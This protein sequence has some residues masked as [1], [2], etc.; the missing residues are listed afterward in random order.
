[1]EADVHRSQCGISKARTNRKRERE[2]E[3]C[4]LATVKVGGGATVSSA[5]D[6]P[7]ICRD[8]VE[9]VP[10]FVKLNWRS[11]TTNEPNLREARRRNFAAADH[12]DDR[13]NN[14]PSLRP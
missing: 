9:H 11:T 12:D 4:S 2:G 5:N 10:E 3:N 1:M 7:R 8:S 13:R 14:N 6:R